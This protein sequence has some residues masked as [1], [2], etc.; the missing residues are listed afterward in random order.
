MKRFRRKWRARTRALV[1]VV[2]GS[3]CLFWALPAA[4][5]DPP[6]SSLVLPSTFPGMV[7]AA[8]GAGNGPVTAGDLDLLGVNP[9]AASTAQADLSDGAF[10]G[11]LRTWSRQS[12]G[13]VIAIAA[14]RFPSAPAAGGFLAR[15]NH[16]TTTQSGLT[17]DGSQGIAGAS[18]YT[19]G[20]LANGAT[21][22]V[23]F[24]H[25]SDVFMIAV[26]SPSVDLTLADAVTLATRQAAWSSGN[27]VASSSTSW[28]YRVGE[29]FGALAA[30][31]LLAWLLSR[32]ISPRYREGRSARAARRGRSSG[33]GAG[34]YP[35]PP[36]GAK[37][38]GWLPNPV[39]M[40]EEL[41]WNGNEWA[42]RR[43]WLP[44]SGWVEQTAAHAG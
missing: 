11:Y 14:F 44:G 43:R 17:V 25:G 32:W 22:L 33:Q 31:T 27:A 19:I 7:A 38:A 15:A 6:L 28:T 30:A 39:H 18:V 41:F 1:V 4:S 36:R 3:A 23:N 16:A 20:S 37:D 10:S 2:A 8:P 29:I 24:D 26:R 13:D 5:A 21:Q 42:G 9:S 35:P 12:N 40:N 34:A